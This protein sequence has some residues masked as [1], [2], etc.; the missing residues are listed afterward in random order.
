MREVT[1][2]IT[3]YTWAMSV[4]GLQQMVNILGLGGS[5]SFSRSA[6]SFNNV[7]EATSNELGDAMRALFR[8]GDSL[9]RGLVDLFLAPLSFGDWCGGSGAED[10]RG[11]GHGRGRG[12]H[13]GNGGSDDWSG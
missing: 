4:Y 3:S 5:G 9:Q 11:A 2:A 1:K 10:A 8:G 12:A 13:H 7:T 6:Q